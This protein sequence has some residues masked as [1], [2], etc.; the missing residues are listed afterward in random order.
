MSENFSTRIAYRRRKSS[1]ASAVV[2]FDVSETTSSDRDSRKMNGGLFSSVGTGGNDH[3]RFAPTDKLEMSKERH[4]PD[5]P[6][7]EY[8]ISSDISFEDFSRR[9]AAEATSHAF[10]ENEREDNAVTEMANS[11]NTSSRA[12]EHARGET[13][14][15]FVPSGSSRQEEVDELKK[16]FRRMSATADM[17]GGNM[18]AA[19]PESHSDTL[20]GVNTKVVD[21]V[22]QLDSTV[23]SFFDTIRSQALHERDQTQKGNGLV[24]GNRSAQ[25]VRTDEAPRYA[26]RDAAI[27]TRRPV[28]TLESDEANGSEVERF[29][30]LFTEGKPVYSHNESPF[31]KRDNISASHVGHGT[32][33]GSLRNDMGIA[34]NESDSGGLKRLW[35]ELAAA[36]HTE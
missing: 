12:R 27:V 1:G 10:T 19:S 18:S 30:Q 3:S 29:F 28:R 16:W 6:T 9:L 15:A 21:T 11:S 8:S 33:T 26:Y 31:E 13:E 22:E 20:H 23:L 24:S 17:N 14:K 34:E 7:L 5:R 25:S 32:S 36:N 35:A 2:A 4:L